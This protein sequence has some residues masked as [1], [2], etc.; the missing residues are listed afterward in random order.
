MRKWFGVEQLV[1]LTILSASALLA[2]LVSRMEEPAAFQQISSTLWPVTLIITLIVCSAVI[3]FENATGRVTSDP[4]E[5][6]DRLS[7]GRQGWM[8]VGA[9]VL[10]APAMFYVGF[11][12]SSVAL[13]FAVMLIFDGWNRPLRAVMT[14]ILLPGFVYWLIADLLGQVLPVGILF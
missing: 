1:P 8:L 14:S 7:R 2:V 12:V 5:D 9:I 6:D 11:I 3:F 13:T 4:D 10:F